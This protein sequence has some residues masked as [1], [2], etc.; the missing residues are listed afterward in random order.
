MENTPPA[1]RSLR[2]LIGLKRHGRKGLIIALLVL[3]IG[4]PVVW[5]KGT[6]YYLAE[7]TFQVAP[8]YQKT[9]SADKELELQ[10]NSQYREF[11]NHLSR[12]LLRYDVLER[13]LNDLLARGINP[14]LPSED[15]RKCIERWQRTVT[16]LPVAD[17][18]M[19]RVSLQ[20]TE[21]KD[22]HAIVNAIMD[23]FLETTKNEQIYGSDSRGR[24]L[25]ERATRVSLELEQLARERA[26]LA[27]L[28]GLTTFGENSVNPYDNTLA[29]AREK[30]TNAQTERSQARA[31]LDAFSANKEVP[32]SS[33]RSVLEMRLQ[34]NGLQ[35]MRN[36]VIKRSQEL[37]RTV[38]G[39]QDSHPAKLPALEEHDEINRRLQSSEAAFEKNAQMNLR[40]RF[41]ASVQQ[42][43]QVE[44]ELQARVREIESQASKYAVNFR[45]A[46]R[47]TGEIKNREQDLTDIRNRVNYLET[48]SNALGFVRLIT[49]ALPAITPQ[50]IGKTKMLLALLLVC[51]ALALAT[52]MLLDMLDGRVLTVGDAEKA[53]GVPTAA[54]M[55]DRNDV[56]TRVLARDQ[57]RRFASTLS[58]NCA[59]G[60][61]GVFAFS[62]VKAEG[63][64]AQ[65]ILGVAHTLQQLGSKVLVVDANSL[66][67]ESPLGTNQLGLTDLLAGR[68][69]P[70]EVICAQ[71]AGQCDQ[72]ACVSFGQSRDSGIQRLDLLRDAITQWLTRFDMVL[73]DLP[74]LLPCAD[75]ELLIDAIGQVF[76]VVEAEAVSKA[77]VVRARGLLEKLAPEAVGL[78]VNKLT[79]ESGEGD[80]RARVVENVTGRKFQSFMSQSDISLQLQLLRLRWSRFW[81]DRTSRHHPKTAPQ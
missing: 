57:L 45:E 39:L 29:Q 58:R 40:S 34:D 33:G 60:T 51:T 52:P 35:A 46:M 62:S 67:S 68:A 5:I 28:L 24:V 77:E 50:G 72:L 73:V 11:V 56:P 78:I 18:Y 6:S 42:T 48:E 75:A 76:L 27:G 9:L 26:Q 49:P 4:L 1:G 54:W 65:L 3:L 23:S 66:I 59:R 36:E 55:L 10:S 74:P 81:Q 44:S 19:V 14:K 80:V 38:T 21:K 71:R 32:A 64:S 13:A 70:D 31:T 17:T 12:S 63:E 37:N 41:L 16:L 20:S 7:A 30:L 79:L 61:R 15:S 69:T 8:S 53:F 47:I 25:A 43:Q 2:P 22:L